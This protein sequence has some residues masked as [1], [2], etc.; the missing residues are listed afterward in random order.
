M[1]P[2]LDAAVAFDP[3]MALY[4]RQRGAAYFQRGDLDRAV[5]DLESATRLN[6]ADDLAW[7]TLAMAHAADGDAAAGE[8]A[9]AQAVELHR[10]DPVNLL[11]TAE[12]HTSAG[13]PERAADLLAEVVQ[14]WPTTVLAHGWEAVLPQSL[15]TSSVVD[16]A[17]ERWE[18]GDPMPELRGDQGLWLSTMAGRGDLTASQIA[19][20]G[21]SAAMGEV[22]VMAIRCEPTAAA[23]DAMDPIEWRSYMYWWL[24]M[25]AD[26]LAGGTGEEAGHMAAL[27]GHGVS[28]E[29]ATQTSNPL[30][31]SGRFGGA[32]RYGYRRLAVVW[33]DAGI[34]LPSSSTGMVRWLFDPHEAAISAALEP[35]LEACAE[36]GG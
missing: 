14:A 2:A 28:A 15:A 24:R 23:Q 10:S 1:V 29:S 25:Q 17:L 20:S 5:A 30:N 21:W 9:L 19:T 16:A 31:P 27:M 13:R 12:A 7:R 26:I 32:D 6:R 11:L 33:P 4:V 8:A 3:G 22:L 35:T 36:A 34:S 18:G